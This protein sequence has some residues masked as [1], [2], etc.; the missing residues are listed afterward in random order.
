MRASAFGVCRSAGEPPDQSGGA[1]M[2]RG[3]PCWSLERDDKVRKLFAKG[4]D[5]AAIRAAIGDPRITEAAV[6]AR[7]GT[8]GL[9]AR[10]VTRAQA[11]VFEPPKA[12]GVEKVRPTK[13]DIRDLAKLRGGGG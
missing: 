1:V 2:P 7:L 9:R 8:L 6:T 5:A 11:P 4:C 10:A 13:D 3:T 12:E